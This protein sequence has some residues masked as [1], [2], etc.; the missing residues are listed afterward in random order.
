MNAER[1]ASVNCGDSYPILHSLSMESLN[2][3]MLWFYQLKYEY[4][5]GMSKLR[6][7]SLG[8]WSRFEAKMNSIWNFVIPLISVVSWLGFTARLCCYVLSGD[9]HLVLRWRGMQMYQHFEEVIGCVHCQCRGYAVCIKSV[10]Y[11]IKPST[12]IIH[13]IS[14]NLSSNAGEL[15]FASRVYGTLAKSTHD[16][17]ILNIYPLTFRN[18]WQCAS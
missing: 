5:A 16:V 1:E 9:C 12:G 13:I 11:L 14:K 2:F 7:C 8:F 18:W 4:S 3:D 6:R 17:S 10:V 15:R